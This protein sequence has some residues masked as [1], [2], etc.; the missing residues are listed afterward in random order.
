MSIV[1]V[2][3]LP[4]PYLLKIVFDRVIPS[5]D[6]HLLSLII[7]LLVGA[8]ITK[9]L[10]ALLTDY[11][12]N[13]LSQEITA[14]MKRHLFCRVLGLPLSYFNTAHTG[15]ILSRAE[16]V[17]SIKSF[18]SNISM[19]LLL[20]FFDFAFCLTI[21]FSLSTKLTLLSLCLLPVFYI[22][23]RYSSRVSRRLARIAFESA[24]E[25]TR[26]IQDSLSGVEVIKFFNAEKR[27]T[28]KLGIYIDDHKTNIIRKNTSFAVSSELVSFIGAL[29]G[30]IVLWA[31]GIDI[32]KGTFTIGSFLAFSAY[33]ARLYGPTQI[34]ANVGITLQPTLV[35]ADRYFE[36]IDLSGE[37]D[38][39]NRLK[40]RGINR[41]IEFIDVSFS[42]EKNQV[43]SNINIDIKSGE[44]VLLTG[45]N[46]SGKTTLIKL[47]LGL[48]K[49]NKGLII[50]DD[51]NIAELMLS[52]LRERISVVAQNTFLF[53]D[54]IRN[55][56]LYSCP[57]AKEEQLHEA[58]KLS[59]AYDFISRLERGFETVVGERG[60]R[61]SGGEKQ[62]IAIARAILRDADVIILDEAHTHLDERSEHILYE[63]IWGIF[64]KKTCLIISHKNIAYLSFNKI[65]SLNHGHIEVAYPA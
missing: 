15:Y 26:H 33:A 29:G 16:E 37:M 3:M 27:E 13:L 35:A 30:Y 63:L 48:Y 23:I 62:K 17:E 8:Q 43:L 49:A 65:F 41:G 57:D 5:K 21:M 55:N 50:I 61:L 6:V 44:K 40:I 12:F 32:I 10:F 58:A 28:D 59:G 9:T 19:R 1:S 14:S 4:F 42:Y 53:N 34:L 22:I 51:H 25:V 24:A 39:K 18:F 7:A 2:L 46:G 52:S 60:V 45:P 20:G 31:C 54:T 56:I 11:Q 36:L 38:S 47:L 64:R